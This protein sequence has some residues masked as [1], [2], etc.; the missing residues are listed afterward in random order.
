MFKPEQFL[1]PRCTPSTVDIY[2]DR[3]AILRALRQA[4]P[5]MEGTLLDIGCGYMPYKPLVL[6]APTRVTRY[7][8]MDFANGDYQKP[9]IA[10]NGQQIPLDDATVDCAMAT[11]VFEHCPEP[12]ELMRE[13]CRVLK[14]HGVLFFTVPFLWPLH[15]VPHDEYRFT[16]FAMRRLLQDAGF[17]EIQLNAQ[18]GWDA[19]LAQMIGLWARRRPMHRWLRWMMSRMAVPVVRYLLTRD[20]PPENFDRNGMITG[21]S[22][23]ARKG[24]G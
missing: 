2:H 7:I 9:D 11:E 5:L 18:G 16:P 1:S 14:P 15:D 10:W 20:R 22:G 13:C 21:L 12:G 17:G 19:S 23:T 4:L 24:M 3:R 6:A 8:G